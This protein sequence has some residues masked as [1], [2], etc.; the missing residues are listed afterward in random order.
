MKERKRG[1]AEV[2][3][4]WGSLGYVAIQLLQLVVLSLIGAAVV[5]LPPVAIY[6]LAGL[7]FS[8]KTAA[9]LS[10]FGGVLMLCGGVL[11]IMRRGE[12]SL[13]EGRDEDGD[14]Q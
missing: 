5:F 14:G 10:L 2:E 3:S 8:Q 6:Y 4:I 11:F 1:R 12:V 9:A 13:R 7:I